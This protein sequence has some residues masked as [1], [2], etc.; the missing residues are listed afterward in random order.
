M[1]VM[2]HQTF[3]MVSFLAELLSRVMHSRVVHQFDLDVLHQ[4]TAVVFLESDYALTFQIH[5]RLYEL[6]SAFEV[7]NLWLLNLM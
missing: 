3:L 2:L 7:H 6:Q 1:A 5:S 4:F